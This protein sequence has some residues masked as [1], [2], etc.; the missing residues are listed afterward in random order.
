MEISAQLNQTKVIYCPVHKG[1]ARNEISDSR[2]K[3]SCKNVP[4]YSKISLLDIRKFNK[5]LT[6]SKWERRF[7]NLHGNKYKQK[8]AKIG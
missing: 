4:P 6:A 7:D 3:I 5:K 1:I 2:T 8:V